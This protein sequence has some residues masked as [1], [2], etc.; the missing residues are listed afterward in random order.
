MRNKRGQEEIAG[1]YFWL[2]YL[3]MTAI[4]VLALVITP[5]QILNQSFQ[6]MPVDATIMEQRLQNKL[7]ATSAIYGMQPGKLT[8]NV[9]ENI[10]LGLSDKA[11]GFKITV[12][13]Q[14]FFGNQE[15]FEDAK[16]LAPVKYQLYTSSYE[17]TKNNQPVI[18]TVEQTFPFEYGALRS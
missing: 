18:V 5:Q 1:I 17:Y 14:T 15:F 16:P 8:S 2:F 9:Q 10:A 6:P 13:G 11:Y 12:D 3:P 7:S 4:V